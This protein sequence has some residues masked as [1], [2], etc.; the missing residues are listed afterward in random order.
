[1][2]VHEII[3]KY[4]NNI[5]KLIEYIKEDQSEERI[6]K[7]KQYLFVLED[8][9]Y[10]NIHNRIINKLPENYDNCVNVHDFIYFSHSYNNKCYCKK[11]LQIL[12][13]YYGRDIILLRNISETLLELINSGFNIAYTIGTLIDITEKLN[14]IEKF[15][16]HEFR[17]VTCE[18]SNN[19][20]LN[21]ESLLIYNN[22][23]L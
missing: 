5:L 12:P 15:V 10:T 16:K 9:I 13:R 6:I 17:L 14:K 7:Y 23:F 21:C 3:Q 20:C 19:L 22:L 18:D 8:K 4:I 1:M 2:F 11:Y